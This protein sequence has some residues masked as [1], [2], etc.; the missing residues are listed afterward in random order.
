MATNRI[1]LRSAPRTQDAATDTALQQTYEDMRRI[2]E[3][4]QNEIADLRSSIPNDKPEKGDVIERRTVVRGGT[5]ELG[6]NLVHFENWN[7]SSSKWEIRVHWVGTSIVASVRI[8]ITVGDDVTTVNR[9]GRQGDI[10]VHRGIGS[11]TNYQV[12]ITGYA[13]EDQGGDNFVLY[14]TSDRTPPAP[15]AGSLS[16]E[17]PTVA[18]ES[19][20]YLREVDATQGAA[21]YSWSEGARVPSPGTTGDTFALRQILSGSA[22]NQYADFVFEAFTAII[23]FAINTFG[24]R[25][26]E[27]STPN[28][29]RIAIDWPDVLIQMRAWLE[30]GTGINIT[31]AVD[32]SEGIRIENTGIVGLGIN[33]YGL[34]LLDASTPTYPRIAVDWADVL[35]QVRS[36]LE[37][38]TGIQI[39]SATGQS[40]G[41]RINA[42]GSGFT[43]S[44][45]NLY[46]AVLALLAHSSGINVAG[47]GTSRITIRN[48]GVLGFSIQTYG[49]SLANTST[50]THPV[51]GLDWGDILIQIRAW[52]E[53]GGGI[54]ITSAEDQSEGIRIENTGIVGFGINT[55]GLRLLDTSTPTY[56][57]VAIDWDDV[58]LQVRAWLEAGTGITIGAATDQS[59]G[60][61]ISADGGG[62]SG[63][64][65]PTGLVGSE[66]SFVRHVDRRFGAPRNSWARGVEEIGLSSSGLG[67][68]YVRQRIRQNNQIIGVWVEAPSG[69]G[70]F[71]PSATNLY[72]AVLAM[73]SSGAGISLTG[74]DV[75]GIAIANTGIIGFAID[76]N[77]LRLLDT[78][79]T[80]YPRIAIDYDDIFNQVKQWFIEGSNV[81]ITKG[82]TRAAGI[83][84]AATG[85]SGGTGG[86]PTEE[87]VFDHAKNIIIVGSGL[88]VLDNDSANTIQISL[89]LAEGDRNRR[90]PIT[91][92]SASLPLAITG[93]GTTRSLSLS[94]ENLFD[95]VKFFIRGENGITVRYTD[96]LSGA[97]GLYIGGTAGGSGGGGTILV[98]SPLVIDG[99]TS[100]ISIH[101]ESLFDIVKGWITAGSGI[102]VSRGSNISNGISISATGDGGGGGG[103]TSTGLTDEQLFDKIKGWFTS[104]TDIFITAGSNISDGIAFQAGASIVTDIRSAH[105]GITISRFGQRV[106]IGLSPSNLPGPTEQ[107][108][109]DHVKNIL[110]G[111]DGI[112]I[113]SND[114]TRTVTIVRD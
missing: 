9:N 103:G 54:N 111:S 101:L 112:G 82:L 83:R 4:L 74:D 71:T 20:G 35:I 105:D 34:R 53:S 30:A 27:T 81:D 15:G 49:L 106:G 75:D 73:L 108:V 50:P 60:I 100:R 28:Y 67:T 7:D 65:E 91:S 109:Y 90:I 22:P 38:G 61:R 68:N 57:R 64:G 44:A 37:A 26:L 99:S 89:D 24:L 41:I 18:N 8:E 29:P 76:T 46:S 86:A 102:S 104:G 84:I 114:A 77:G 59:A 110:D 39:T 96:S 40:E 48:T 16:N 69:G 95:K 14:E 12:R 5:N 17:P 52:L 21:A 1:N 58:L 45:T 92:L 3:T 98:S 79:T 66:S 6:G 32:Q 70:S 87:Q 13:E 62:S 94:S 33:T 113:S 47:D 93:S 31:S 63:I 11:L 43:P 25:L 85:G 2:V 72:A 36:W 23:G 107:Q 80:N 88:D 10:L 97:G 55:Y 42:T 78:S 56:P 19:H 51:V